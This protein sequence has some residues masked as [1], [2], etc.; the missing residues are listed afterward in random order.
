MIWI[1]LAM[2]HRLLLVLLLAYASTAAPR[3]LTPADLFQIEK[4][5]EVVPSPDGRSAA[6]VRI[7]GKVTAKFHMRDF[8]SGLDR[9]DVWVTS[10][11]GAEP[12][13][14]SNGATD[15]SGWFLPAWSPDGERLA[16]L[17]T[18]GDDVRLWVWDR[19]NG[20]LS[21]VSN[22]GVEIARP[23]W[24]SPDEVLCA[25]VPAG[26][27]A[28]AFV[29]EVQGAEESMRA[30]PQAWRGAAT[31]A[32]VLRSGSG[33]RPQRP[34]GDVWGF[35]VSRRT[36]RKVLHGNFTGIEPSPDGRRIA[37]LEAADIVRPDPNRLLPN[38]NP[39]KYKLVV[40]GDLSTQAEDV[41]PGSLRWSRSGKLALQSRV[42]RRP[43]DWVIVGGPNLT[44]TF[45]TPP[46]TLVPTDVGDGFVGVADG[47]LWLIDA[48]GGPPRLVNAEF[49]PRI[50]SLVWPDRS[51]IVVGSGSDLY[52]VELK[53]AEF[54]RLVRPEASAEF[55]A[56]APKTGIATYVA[57]SHGRAS[58]WVAG[59]KIAFANEFLDQVQEGQLKHIE[60][61]GQDGQALSGWLLLPGDYVEGRKYPTVVWVYGGLTYS[62]TPPPFWV[63]LGDSGPYSLQLLTARGYAVL[64]PSMPLKP[65][66]VPSDPYLELTNGVLPAVDKAIELGISDPR[67]L[68]LMGQSFGGYSVYGLVTQT[69][70]FQ[71]AVAL[72]GFCNLVSVYGAIDPRFRFDELARERHLHMTFAE[73]GQNRMGA[74]PWKDMDRY[75]RNSPITHAE[76]VTTPLLIVQGDM[77]YVP[78]QQGE[79]FFTALYRQNK[80]AEFVRYWGEGHI[81]ESPANVT[82]LWTRI[83]GWLAR[84]LN[85]S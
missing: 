7:R 80:P 71:A 77:D 14:L 31:T 76:R 82:D 60:Y 30:I 4:F 70:R 62:A 34:A 61:R 46:S 13:N 59:H 52:A 20:K 3:P 81:I 12:R 6:Y 73:S 83:Y 58:L 56:F 22:T 26:R 45:Q 2:T 75:V 8:M 25:G 64:L 29:M 78:I 66:T 57:V 47:R 24:L 17:S 49:K 53:T 10:A 79:E 33:D 74:P 1:G 72:A 28:A 11:A 40:A 5:G 16:M 69:S 37:A 51:T 35:D 38:R 42:N 32:S 19:K 67:R 43:N 9:A 85:P 55:R 84:Y 18:R 65:E 63:H 48:G 54:R 36:A 50:D 27:K 15:G 41:V 39:I 21:Q 44:S 68:A 23:V